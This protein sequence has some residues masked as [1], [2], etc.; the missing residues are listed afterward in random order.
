M[1]RENQLRELSLDALFELMLFKIEEIKLLRR[2]NA[3]N[4]TLL[5]VVSEIMLI[6]EAINQKKSEN[7]NRPVK[8]S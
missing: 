1:F 8:A 4:E 3:N 6:Q 7:P 2:E 5:Q